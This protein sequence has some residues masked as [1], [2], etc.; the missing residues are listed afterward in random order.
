MVNKWKILAGLVT[1]VLLALGIVFISDAYL[2]SCDGC[3]CGKK[4]VCGKQGG[5]GEQPSDSAKAETTRDDDDPGC[6]GCTPDNPRCP[7]RLLKK[8]DKLL[9][10]ADKTKDVASLMKHCEQMLNRAAEIITECNQVTEGPGWFDS[11]SV[12]IATKLMKKCVE[13]TTKC[14]SLIP[15]DQKKST[16]KKALYKCP[17]GC[18]EPQDKPG[19]CSKCGM[20]LEKMK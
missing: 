19:K 2:T 5:H 18:V 14:Q 11:Q 4:G 13:I 15:K 12:E 8:A 17:M 3:G 6:H 10:E 20:N 7:G 1:L 16:E 9:K